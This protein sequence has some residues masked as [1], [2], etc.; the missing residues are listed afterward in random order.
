MQPDVEESV[1]AAA[2][3]LENLGAEIHHVSLPH[4]HFAVAVYYIVATAEASSNLSRYDGVHYGHRTSQAADIIELYQKSRR[5]GFGG[6]VKRRIM[7]GTFALSAG[8]HDAYYKKALQVRALIK[9]DFDEAFRNVDILLAPTSPTTAFKLGEKLSDPLAMYLSDVFTIS[10]NLAAIPAISIPCGRDAGGLPIGLQ[11]MG[12]AWS[13]ATL[14]AAA[15]RLE[16]ALAL[17]PIVADPA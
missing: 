3:L 17:A 11:I 16:E 14:F 4:T 7:L 6:E 2:A 8:Y 10:A 1:R 13:E 9:H 15:A 12:P 5:E